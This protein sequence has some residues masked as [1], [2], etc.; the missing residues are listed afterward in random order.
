MG[1]DSAIKDRL[2][3]LFTER[4]PG[5]SFIYRAEKP[6]EL[7]F[8]NQAMAD[9]F[10]CDTVEEFDEFVGHSFDGIVNCGQLATVQKEIDL[11]IE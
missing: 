1:Y 8:A 11:Q 7:L 4:M 3:S 9:L 10:E 5:G 2:S 6:H